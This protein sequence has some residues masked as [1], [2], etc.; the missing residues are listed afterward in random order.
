M[1]EVLHLM[2]CLMACLRT[3]TLCQGQLAGFSSCFWALAAAPHA[4]LC[5]SAASVCGSAALE[6]PCSPVL[7]PRGGKKVSWGASSPST[8][9]RVSKPPECHLWHGGTAA[10]GSRHREPRQR[11]EPAPQREAADEGGCGGD[12]PG[13]NPARFGESSRGRGESLV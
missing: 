5:S 2:A 10:P 1:F 11:L 6:V 4:Q 13:E 9:V 8:A 12:V 3:E 7:L